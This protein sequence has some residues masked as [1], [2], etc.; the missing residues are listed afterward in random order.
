MAVCRISYDMGVSGVPQNGWF[1]LENPI[2]MDDLKVPLFLETPIYV[3]EYTETQRESEIWMSSGSF[4]NASAT[5][6]EN[7]DRC[8]QYDTKRLHGTFLPSKGVYGKPQKC[9]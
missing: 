3:Y 2:E 5:W 4:S 6:I 8:F 9:F 7:D 1:I